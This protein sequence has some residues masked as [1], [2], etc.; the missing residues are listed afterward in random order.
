MPYI[1]QWGRGIMTSDLVDSIDTK[2]T[3]DT[4]PFYREVK[5]CMSRLC[6]RW[7]TQF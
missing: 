5:T 4:K 7:K 3:K 6:N 2:D 1:E